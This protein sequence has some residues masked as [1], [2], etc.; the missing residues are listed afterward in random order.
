MRVDSVRGMDRWVNREKGFIRMQSVDT[1][2][3]IGGNIKINAI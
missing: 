3:H 1:H 2:A